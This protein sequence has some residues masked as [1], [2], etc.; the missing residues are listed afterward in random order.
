MDKHV[1]GVHTT[2]CCPRHG[3]KYSSEDCPIKNGRAEPVYTANNGCEFCEENTVYGTAHCE[4]EWTF[5]P[6]IKED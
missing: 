4:L 2:H 3:C 5:Y 1:E 6:T